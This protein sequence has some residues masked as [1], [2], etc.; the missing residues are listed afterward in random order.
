MAADETI[1]SLS[2]RVRASCA[3]GLHQSA[4]IIYKQFRFKSELPAILFASFAVAVADR[5]DIYVVGPGP[6]KRVP[7]AVEALAF[8]LGFDEYL[9]RE[10]VVDHVLVI[11]E[12][13]RI[14]RK[15]HVLYYTDFFQAILQIF[16]FEENFF[17]TLLRSRLP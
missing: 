15:S 5:F 2:R 6:I 13:S 9:A 11:V 14:Y 3:K 16:Q 8:S 10:P 7:D 4:I 17:A 12:I 1:P